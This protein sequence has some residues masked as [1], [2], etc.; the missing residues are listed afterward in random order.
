MNQ[1]P[2]FI[3]LYSLI[4]LS[5]TMNGQDNRPQPPVISDGSDFR[6]IQQEMNDFY[7]ANPNSRGY[8]QWKRKEWFLAPRLYPSGKMEN[9]TLKTW[10]AYDRYMKT[11]PNDRATHGSWSF[12]GPSSHPGGLGRL[13]TIAFHPTNPDIMYV[14][15]SNGG[16][17]KTTNGGSSWS[18]VS[19]NIPLL[20]VADI[21]IS[22][23]NP[24]VIYVLTGDGDP[25][26]IENGIHGQTEVSSIG[27]LRSSDAGATWHPTNYSLDH[28]SGVI[29]LKLLIHPSNVNIQMVATQGGIIRTTDHWATWTNVSAQA[30]FD[31]EYKPGD[32]NIVY[33]AGSNNIRRSTDGGATFAAVTDSDFSNFSGASRIE[34]AVTPDN[35]N[36]VYALAGN[37][38]GFSAFLESQSSGANN[39]WTLRN[40]SATTLGT[41]T[42]YCVGLAVQPNDW[43][44]VFGGMQWI[45][46]SL[47]QGQTWTSVVQNVV[48][49]DIH[50]VAYTNGALWV[51]HDG[52]LDKSTNEGDT[53]TDLTTGMAI[54]EVYRI[55]GTPQ[56]TELY[57]V[58]C[59]DNGNMRRNGNT[60]AFQIAT[61][62]DGMTPMVDY[63]NANIVYVSTQN[64][65]FFKS[66][67]GGAQ[68]TFT[69]LNIPGGS[70]A[71][72]T[73]A[74]MDPTDPQRLF[75]GKINVYR[76]TN[77]GSTWQNIGAPGTTNLNCL[78]QGTSNTSRVYASSGNNIYRTDNA[79]AAAAD[80]TWTNITSGLPNLSITGI[81][82]D[83]INSARVFVTLSGYVDGSKVFRS[84]N[85]GG[86]W[87]NI[88]GSLPNVPANC[89]KIH[90]IGNDN[91]YI[92]TDIGVFYRNNT[93]GDWIYYSNFLPAVNISDLYINTGDNTV[94]AGT[95]GRGLWRSSLY[96]GCDPNL[97]LISLFGIPVGGTRFYSATNWITSSVPYRMDIG[98][99]IHY[100]AG[101]YIEL[102][103]G[104]EAGGRGFFE[105]RIGPCP[106][107]Y[108][109]PMHQPQVPSGIFVVK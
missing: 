42:T 22:P 92:G 106:D 35:A 14:G 5:F 21:K 81:A 74:I 33:A 91:L 43:T 53:W 54:T 12:L 17:W 18:N 28:P 94:V 87:V 19:P 6:I 75:V 31:I 103:E 23:S 13:N 62:A 56:N 96:D 70:G 95:Y 104:F 64:G 20:S 1:L 4:L 109:A 61:G 46:R 10:K 29:P 45:N 26:P 30:T 38:N 34:L 32:P 36:V 37:W 102:T 55:A 58:G 83:P 105:A 71:W 50:D 16:V 72:I 44:D 76:S 39:T 88:S 67:S 57:F 73:P 27:I 66:E 69:Q 47:N 90:N 60:T 78:A 63:T 9:I 80:V 40:N 68:G 108:T 97:S 51:C 89:I 107:I 49:A 59:Q 84:T 15:A 82:V 7:A 25:V 86:T 48:H 93:L 77:G 101:N 79:L 8:K 41:F 65:T 52:G 2:R 3:A 99:E 100:R 24:N 98:N 11:M 85:A